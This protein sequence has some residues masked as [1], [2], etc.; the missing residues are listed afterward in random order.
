[1]YPDLKDKVI[2]ITGAGGNLGVATAVYFDRA[3]SK[4]ALVDHRTDTFRDRFGDKFRE[5]WLILGADITNKAQVDK[6]VAD[7]LTHFGQIDVLIN[8]AGGYAGGTKI[9]ETTEETWDHMLNLN[10]KS[11]FLMSG[12]VAKVMVERGQGGRIISVGA[13]PGLQGTSNHSAYSASKS[14]VLRLTE[15]MAA[16]LRPHK[17]TVNAVL[18]SMLDTPANRRSTPDADFSKWVTPESMAGVIGFLASEAAR[19]VSGALLPVY[20][21]L[22]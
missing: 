4:L 11:V 10:A 8:I 5:T 19:D 3:G 22:G 15:S 20:G 21:G 13:K 18:P 9:F 14:A 2:L 6:L 1:M 16:E 7:T 12:A 17:I